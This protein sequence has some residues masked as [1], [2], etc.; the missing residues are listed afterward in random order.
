MNYANI[1]S[2]QKALNKQIKMAR[3]YLDGVFLNSQN[4]DWWWKNDTDISLCIA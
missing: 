4:R 2:K 1:C 3:G